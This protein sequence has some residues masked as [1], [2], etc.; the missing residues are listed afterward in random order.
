STFTRTKRFQIDEKKAALATYR[1]AAAMY[2]VRKYKEAVENFS[3]FLRL[4]AARNTNVYNYANYGLAYAAFRNN[5]FAMAADYFERFLATD[6]HSIDENVRHDVIARLGDSYLS[7]RDYGR[8]NKY[9]DQLI[10]SKAPN[11]DYA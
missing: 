3:R 8:A 11:Q 7:I 5:S 10:N 1:K 2:E 6:G 9:Y 4:P